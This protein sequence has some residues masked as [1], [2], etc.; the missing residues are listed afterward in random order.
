[1]IYVLH[2]VSGLKSGGVESMLY[3]YYVKMDRSKIHFDFLV[4][5]SADGLFAEKFRELGCDIYCLTPKSISVIKNF[6]DMFRGLSQRNY[7]VVHS[8]IG[9]E[10]FLPLSIAFFKG[11]NVRIAGAHCAIKPNFIAKCMR[12]IT[13]VFANNY[14]ACSELSAQITFNKRKGDFFLLKNGVDVQRFLFNEANRKMIREK[15]DVSDNCVLLGNVGRFVW[16]KNQK[17]LIELLKKM[18]DG[19]LVEYKLMLVGSGGLKDSLQKRAEEC[20]VAN[21]VLFVD[22]Q[23]NIELYYS[24]FDFFMFPSTNEG[25]GIVAI[26]AQINGLNVFASNTLS[27]D[28]CISSRYRCLNINVIDEWCDALRKF[29]YRYSL[30]NRTNLLIDKSSYDIDELANELTSYYGKLVN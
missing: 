18:N 12:L 25:F 8:H 27:S 1:M 22:P 6:R 16:E 2:V 21:K 4:H 19:S 7:D 14:A 3:S 17:F 29:D 10:S 5:G 15:Y 26:E 11:V 28:L 13:S 20:G 30:E 24:A 23:K 9:T